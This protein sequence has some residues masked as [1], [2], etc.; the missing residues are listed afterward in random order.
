MVQIWCDASWSNGKA[1]LGVVIRRINEDATIEEKTCSKQIRC[2]N[3]NIAELEAILYGLENMGARDRTP[4]FIITDSMYAIDTINNPD[5]F[6]GKR[7]ELGKVIRG[8]IGFDKFRVYH[9]K[10]HSKNKDV[11]SRRQQQTDDLAG[12]IRKVIIN[13]KGKWSR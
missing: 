7:K 12:D 5:Q 10:G 9:K 8:I 2:E 13:K 6:H 11:Y 1:G 3:N 4:I